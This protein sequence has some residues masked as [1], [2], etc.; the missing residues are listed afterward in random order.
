[1]YSSLYPSIILENNLAPNTQIGRIEIPDKIYEFEN[2][3]NVEKWH[4]QEEFADCIM[5]QNILLLCSRWFGLA[6]YR[7]LVEDVRE[8]FLNIYKY[9]MRYG[10]QPCFYKKFSSDECVSF[11]PN[12]IGNFYINPVI[13]HNKMPDT[14]GY[15][16][17]LRRTVKL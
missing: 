17:Q 11:N 12:L 14:S 7:E 4:R 5:T 8:Y 9:D 10:Y 1:M 15:K 6:N 2:R 13:F 16:E 3:F